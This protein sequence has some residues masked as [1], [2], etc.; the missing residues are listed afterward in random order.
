MA[1]TSER[2]FQDEL[3]AAFN[4]AGGFAYKGQARTLVGVPDLRIQPKGR[5]PFDA[6]SIALECKFV[7]MEAHMGRVTKKLEAPQSAHLTRVND[8]GGIGVW[9]VGYNLR[10]RH[11]WGMFLLH[12]SLS[13]VFPV[14]R[15]VI[16][17][18][19]APGHY[20]KTRGGA[21]DVQRMIEDI[22]RSYRGN[23]DRTVYANHPEN[24]A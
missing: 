6:P 9:A 14:R 13:V 19:D 11:S 2:G 23:F 16:E 10:G 7:S 17:A 12:P 15:N 22:Y 21:W 24:G 8:A 1:M 4:A 18:G 20:V 5:T 3:V